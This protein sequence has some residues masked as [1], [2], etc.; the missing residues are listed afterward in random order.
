MGLDPA[1]F[2]DEDVGEIR[3]VVGSEKALAAY[4]GGVDS[5]VAAV[6]AEMALG[7]RLKVDDGV[8][9][10]REPEHSLKLE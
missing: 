7:E 2:V 8:R 1:R 4:S 9:R 6:L 5:T 3:Q 10:Y